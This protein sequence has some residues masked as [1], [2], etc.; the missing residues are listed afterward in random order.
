MKKIGILTFQ[1]TV[2]YGAQLQNFSLQE[3]ISNCGKIFE[4]YVINYNNS[5]INSVEKNLY[6]KEQKNIKDFIKYIKNGKSKRS[7][8]NKFEDF[9]KKYINLTDEY[10]IENIDKLE[11]ILDYYIVG[12][13]QVWNLDITGDDY[14]YFLDFVKN[15]NKKYS[16]AASLGKNSFN[17][18]QENKV[19]NL[20]SK[21][22]VIYVR[23]KSAEKYL[24]SLK[25]K[26]V[27][28]VMDPTFL[29]SKEEWV[30][31]FKIHFSY[32]KQ[33]YILVYMIDNIKTNFKKIKRFAKENN[34]K[35]IYIT[36]DFMSVSNVKNIRDASP[37]DFLNYICNA[38]FVVTGS[39]HAICFSLIFNKNFFYILN[40][41]NG[42]N[43]RIL[44]L[45]ELTDINDYNDITEKQSIERINLNYKLINDNLDRYI[46]KSKNNLK[47]I[48]EEWGA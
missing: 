34:L 10:N 39:F 15:D 45:M 4:T 42:R 36:S 23:E 44:D 3:Y 12:S 43:S 30:N 5:T 9:R 13:D 38:E 46:T 22:K 18:Q 27:E 32:E 11:E 14:T 20:L 29:L 19:H 35:I 1:S 41:S 25:I 33:K 16:Y 37:V 26:N 28:T 2:N 17:F 40:K 21:F 31:K 24:K 48:I 6:L 47:S 8:W 7:K